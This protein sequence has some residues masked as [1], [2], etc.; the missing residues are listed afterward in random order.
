MPH[1]QHLQLMHVITILG[2]VL[3]TIQV[4]LISGAVQMLMDAIQQLHFYLQLMVQVQLQ[5]HSSFFSA[6]QN[7]IEFAVTIQFG[8][9]VF[10]GVA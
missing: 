3:H 1:H 9:K 2:M 6:I 5:L 7:R 8:T 10:D 4:E